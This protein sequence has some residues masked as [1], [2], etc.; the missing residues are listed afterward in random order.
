MKDVTFP[1]FATAI[2][3][4][5]KKLDSTAVDGVC[6]LLKNGQELYTFQ[7]PQSAC[8]YNCEQLNEQDPDGGWTY[9]WNPLG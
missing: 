3:K 4:F 1:K 6:H 2:G 9:K 5:E 7:L 8:E